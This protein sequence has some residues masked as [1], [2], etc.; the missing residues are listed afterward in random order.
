M[1]FDSLCDAICRRF[2]TKKH[3]RE[4]LRECASTTVETI[5]LKN[6]GKKTTV[7]SNFIVARLKDVQSCII[8]LPE[9]GMIE[10]QDFLN[11][12]KNIKEYKLVDY[13]HADDLG[14]VIS[15]LQSLITEVPRT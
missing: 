12:V 13:K 8:E 7:C 11:A 6:S 2:L 15:D 14:G 1:N 5:M 10:L 4:L 3:T 9:R